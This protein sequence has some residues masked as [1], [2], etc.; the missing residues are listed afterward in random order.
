MQKLVS[1]IP[2]VLLLVGV[3]AQAA[4]DRGSDAKLARAIEAKPVSCINL[5][6]IRSSRIIDR[7]AIVYEVSGGTYYVN[8]PTSGAFSLRSGLILVTDTHSSQ[9]CSIDIV[10]LYDSMSRMELGAIGLGKFTPYRKPS[11]P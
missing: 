11:R 10:R 3:S 7:T 2:A 5:R 4:T 1:L 8:R 6:D 9:L